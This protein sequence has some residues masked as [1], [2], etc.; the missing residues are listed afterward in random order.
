MKS[1]CMN[2]ISTLL[3]T[4]MFAVASLVACNG[5]G[6][7]ASDL[8]S[9]GATPPANPSCTN[10]TNWKGV[11]IGMSATQVESFLGKPAKIVA[12][13]AQ[14]E[15]TYEACRVFAIFDA[16]TGDITS[17]TLIP[18]TVVLSGNRGVI[19]INTPIRLEAISREV[20]PNNFSIFLS[21][22]NPW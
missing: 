3:A 20:D 1:I 7:N 5:G 13:P 14:T 2:K 17:F 11:G 12:T 4:V 18:G 15:Y 16:T 6:T 10:S 19:S 21:N 22:S 9:S 8:S